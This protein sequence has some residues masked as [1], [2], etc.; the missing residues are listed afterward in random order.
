MT[1]QPPHTRTSSTTLPPLGITLGDPSGIGPEIVLKLHTQALPRAC[2]VYGDVGVLQRTAQQWGMGVQVNP[3]KQLSD[4]PFPSAVAGQLFVL[5]SGPILNV[6]LPV[7]SVNAS[8]GQAAFDAL[9]H[10]ID[11]SLAGH[12]AGIVTA[13]ISKEAMHLAGVPFPGHTEIL[14]HRCGDMPVAMVLVN[15]QL[16]VIL[17]TIHLSLAK[18][19]TAITPELEL[20]TIT[21]AHTVCM[22]LG[23]PKPR[24]AVAGLNPHAGEAGRFG[25][26]EIDTI[27]PAIRLA[28]ANGIDAS[29]PWPGDTI[30]FRARRG[31]FDMVVAQYHD[32]GLIPI[33]YM[34][35][36]EGVNMTAGLPIV[37]TSVD[38]GTA[39]DIAGKGIAQAD[40]LRCAFNLANTLTL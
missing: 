25:R 18:V 14:A 8:S 10:A 29:G 7:G 5:Q 1:S 31:E 32:Q 24:I 2:V 9:N 34:G 6:N 4:L 19:P 3:I 22:Q 37:R 16:R 35:I 40:S 33:K 38:H 20:Q 36:D 15:P 27:E 30:F 12:I 17:V 39:F 26:E 28:Q 21:L 13:P 11:D 23:I